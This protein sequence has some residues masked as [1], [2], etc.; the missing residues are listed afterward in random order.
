MV[1][2]Y[3]AKNI[4]VYQLVGIGC[5]GFICV[6]LPNSDICL[7]F[8]FKDVL[9]V[10]VF[11]ILSSHFMVFTLIMKSLLTSSLQEMSLVF[12]FRSPSWQAIL[13]LD[14]KVNR[15]LPFIRTD[16]GQLVIVFVTYAP[17]QRPLSPYEHKSRVQHN[18]V[19]KNQTHTNKKIN[20]HHVRYTFNFSPR[21]GRASASACPLSVFVCARSVLRLV[22]CAVLT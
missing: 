18:K 11:F 12:F 5:S 9:L 6:V 21:V 15:S 7:L 4:V 16:V 13:R 8:A 3:Y 17:T 19:F 14:A 20:M 22:L 2:L 10:I 1:L